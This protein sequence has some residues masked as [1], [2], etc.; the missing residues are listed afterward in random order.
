[1]NQGRHICVCYPA[2]GRNKKKCW[3]CVKLVILISTSTALAM[4][5][6][7]VAKITAD[8]SLVKFILLSSIH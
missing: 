1:M 2:R 6:T 8:A 4:P 5:E 7:A 3:A